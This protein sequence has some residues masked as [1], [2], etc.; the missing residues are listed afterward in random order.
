MQYT[1]LVYPVSGELASVISSFNLYSGIPVLED[2]IF[3]QYMAWIEVLNNKGGL[4]P[5]PPDVVITNTLCKRRLSLSREQRS[6]N[7]APVPC[8]QCF[9][10]SQQDRS[11]ISFAAIKE[12]LLLS[13]RYIGVCNVFVVFAFI[14]KCNYVSIPYLG[15]VPLASLYFCEYS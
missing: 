5:P 15:V 8:E 12:P 10:H 9:H 11:N 7:I 13:K 14:R 3:G 6:T 2:C 1:L 4:L